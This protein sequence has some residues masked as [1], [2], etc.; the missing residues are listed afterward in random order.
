MLMRQKKKRKW[1]KINE[2]I[3]TAAT[4]ATATKIVNAVESRCYHSNAK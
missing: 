2:P 3:D 1:K 4:T